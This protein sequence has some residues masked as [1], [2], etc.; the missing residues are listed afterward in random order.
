MRHPQGIPVLPPDTPKE[1]PG[2]KPCSNDKKG[3]YIVV[4][5]YKVYKEQRNTHAKRGRSP[6][7]RQPTKREHVRRKVCSRV[8]R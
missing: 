2:D 5:I 1:T 4:G 6:A 3:T 7:A 8:N